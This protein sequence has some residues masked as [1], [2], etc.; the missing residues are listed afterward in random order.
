MDTAKAL[1]IVNAAW[2]PYRNKFKYLEDDVKSVATLAIF[3][4]FLSC[5]LQN[6]AKLK[7][8]AEE[9]IIDYLDKNAE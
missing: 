4:A 9:A 3:E 8:I 7:Q 6:E 1:D 2:G 5:H